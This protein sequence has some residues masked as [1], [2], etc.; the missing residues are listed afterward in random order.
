MFK[1]VSMTRST[2]I[3]E[4]SVVRTCSSLDAVLKT[5]YFL[6]NTLNYSR[7]DLWIPIR[8]PGGRAA[9]VFSAEGARRW[10]AHAV[11]EGFLYVRTWQLDHDAHLKAERRLTIRAYE[12]HWDSGVYLGESAPDHWDDEEVDLKLRE[13]Q[14]A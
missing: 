6:V 7:D 12:R 13:V 11:N 14:P 8:E 3:H 2:N 1:I 5:V 9:I 10:S 4:P